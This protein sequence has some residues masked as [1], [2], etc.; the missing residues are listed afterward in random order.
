KQSEPFPRQYTPELQKTA[1]KRPAVE[2]CS[3]PSKSRPSPRLA[4]RQS[5]PAQNHPYEP[6]D[7][8]ADSEYG[9]QI[10]PPADYPAAES[11]SPWD[12]PSANDRNSTTPTPQDARSTPAHPSPAPAPEDSSQAL[13]S[14]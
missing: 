8:H 12:I 9:S 13:H 5:I 14:E 10:R 11:P 1:R 6:P 4:S 3:Y 7:F 2:S